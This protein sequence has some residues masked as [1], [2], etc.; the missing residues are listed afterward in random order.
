MECIIKA[1]DV[2]FREFPIIFTRVGLNRR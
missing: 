1:K 2:A